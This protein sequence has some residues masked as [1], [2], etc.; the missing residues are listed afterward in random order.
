MI[1]DSPPVYQQLH[2]SWKLQ[3]YRV[4]LK[5]CDFYDDCRAFIQSCFKKKL[6]HKNS[7]LT[8]FTFALR[9]LNFNQGYTLDYDRNTFKLGWFEKFLVV[10][11]VASFVDNPVLFRQVIFQHLM[12]FFKS[13]ANFSDVTANFSVVTGTTSVMS[14]LTF[15]QRHRPTA[16]FSDF[17]I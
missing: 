9:F 15:L 4:T 10:A 17:C 13:R 8:V 1:R 16:Y 5:G 2:Q 12:I 7:I 11:E 6:G 3:I 14:Q